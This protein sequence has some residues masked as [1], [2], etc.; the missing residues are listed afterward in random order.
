VNIP[1]DNLMNKILKRGGV[2]F[3]VGGIDFKKR[4]FVPKTGTRPHSIFCGAYVPILVIEIT[5]FDK[6][7]FFFW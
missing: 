1:V 3:F 7:M 4:L 5:N 2:L 6:K